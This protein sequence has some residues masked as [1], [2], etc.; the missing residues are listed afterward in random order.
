[1]S[2][3]SLI[4]NMVGVANNITADLQDTVT[5]A[6]WIRQDGM[7]T[8]IYGRRVNG[9]DIYSNDPTSG[10]VAIERECVVE[11]KQRVR[12]VQGRNVVTQA[13]LTFVHEIEPIEVHGSERKNPVDPRDVIVLPDGTTGPVV[14]VVGVWN[15][16][17]QRFYATEVWLGD[18]SRAGGGA[19]AL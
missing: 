9:L 1:M 11:L 5:H 12:E 10:H 16:E 18:L 17:T 13:H 2:L 14:D 7:G 4:R 8:P 3:N 19:T 15:S 6:A